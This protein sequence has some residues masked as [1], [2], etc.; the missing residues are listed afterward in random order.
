MAAA[1]KTGAR[2]EVWL[3]PDYSW[4][5]VR[6]KVTAADGASATQT[7]SAFIRR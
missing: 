4:Y 3:A 7:V 1:T 5:P 6:L 2:L